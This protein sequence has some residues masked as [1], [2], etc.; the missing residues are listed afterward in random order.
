MEKIEEP[1]EMEFS[2]MHDVARRCELQYRFFK[3][4]MDI[5]DYVAT[6]KQEIPQLKS[7]CEEWERKNAKARAE[8]ETL[9]GER[10]R[11]EAANQEQLALLQEYSEKHLALH[12]IIV[13]QREK[14]LAID[15]EN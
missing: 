5:F 7:D 2:Q 12:E 9:A 4:A 15:V 14:V 1:D 10:E 11:L 3:F 6:L 13:A 8:N